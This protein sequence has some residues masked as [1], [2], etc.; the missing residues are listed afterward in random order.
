MLPARSH[1][2]GRH[3]RVLLA[4][5]LSCA[6]FGCPGAPRTQASPV[7]TPQASS[8]ALALAPGARLPH[9]RFLQCP[10]HAVSASLELT[11]DGAHYT[12]VAHDNYQEARYTQCSHSPDEV[13]CEG[14]WGYSHKG[15]RL[16]ITAGQG[17]KWTALLTRDGDVPAQ[18]DC[19]AGEKRLTSNCL[20]KPGSPSC[21]SP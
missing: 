18:L 13:R 2:A 12:G 9:A 8:P 17:G 20:S 5:A 3:L 15:S 7:S 11:H 1:N 10:G 6:T 14:E 4:C 16:V 21:P 19:V